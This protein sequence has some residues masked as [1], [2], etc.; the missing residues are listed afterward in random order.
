LTPKGH[1]TVVRA[2]SIVSGLSG[3]HVLV[4]V[5]AALLS[6]DPLAY[7][8]TNGLASRSS[9]WLIPFAVIGTLLTSLVAVLADPRK[10]RWSVAI[11]LTAVVLTATLAV[12]TGRWP[13][14]AISLVV[15]LMVWR[16]E[17]VAR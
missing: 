16:L 6:Q 10:G 11:A 7:D 9:P 5:F 13:L 14:L 3:I 1:E 17:D 8:I 2:V 12:V 15:F 4:A